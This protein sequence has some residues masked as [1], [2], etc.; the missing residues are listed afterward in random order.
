MRMM[1]AG[2]TTLIACG[3]ALPVAAQTLSDE[4]QNEEDPGSEIEMDIGK[5]GNVTIGHERNMQSPQ[6]VQV[7]PDAAPQLLD[8]PDSP[9]NED[10]VDA[11]LPGEGPEDLS[12]PAGEDDEPD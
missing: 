2:V 10:A 4:I 6:G 9:V 12:G 1:V 7:N 11:E 5:G 8:D 3:L